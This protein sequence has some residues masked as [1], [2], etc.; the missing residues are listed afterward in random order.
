MEL[1]KKLAHR[2][3]T[4]QYFDSN[5]EKVFDISIHNIVTFDILKATPKFL[6]VDMDG[7]VYLTDT[8][9]KLVDYSSFHHDD[10]FYWEPEQL[11]RINITQ[12]YPNMSI[13]YKSWYKNSENIFPIYRWDR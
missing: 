13:G 3:T 12:I 7:Y 11:D 9:L 2:N 10:V 4:L 1:I 6:Y 8:Q 5:N